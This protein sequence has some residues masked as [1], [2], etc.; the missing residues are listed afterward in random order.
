M[1]SMVSLYLLQMKFNKLI[2][3]SK[4]N[5][6][7]NPSY[8]SVVVPSKVFDLGAKWMFEKLNE[9]NKEAKF[10]YSANY[11][12]YGTLKYVICFLAFLISVFQLSKI[13]VFLTPIS[14]LVFY[15]FEIHFLFLFPLI[16]DN[17]QNPVWASI[18]QTYKIGLLTALVTVIPIG[19]YMVIGLLKFHDPLRNWHIGCLAIIIWYQ[20]EIRDRI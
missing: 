1:V 6:E 7:Q 2:C 11:F 5:L 4:T 14:M 12:T 20:N 8:I 16:I 19:L 10:N 3:Q 17:V 13:S 9:N 18:K 15:L